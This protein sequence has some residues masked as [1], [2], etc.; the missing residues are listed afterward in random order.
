M[1]ILNIIQKHKINFFI[2]GYTMTFIFLAIVGYM[3][4]DVSNNKSIHRDKTDARYFMTDLAMYDLP[5]MNI[6]LSS[7]HGTASH[8]RVEVS[9]EIAKKDIDRLNNYK[10]RITNKIV[11]YMSNQNT[12]KIVSAEG[13]HSLHTGLMEVVESE[14]QPVPVHDIIFRQL[15][16]M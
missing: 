8:I 2:V 5:R 9:L 14:N 16:V 7:G 13:F 4:A 3:A 15:L 6:Y 1:R 12:D 10:P 11:A